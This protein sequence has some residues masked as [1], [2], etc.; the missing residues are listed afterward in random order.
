[1]KYSDTKGMPRL[2]AAEAKKGDQVLCTCGGGTGFLRRG[3]QYVVADATPT[4]Y[5][6]VEGSADYYHAA[7][8]F[9]SPVKTAI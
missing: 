3:K 6:R 8:R 9:V 2:I 5:I 7:A 4:G 1:M